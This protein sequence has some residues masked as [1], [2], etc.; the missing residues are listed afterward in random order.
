M[1]ENEHVEV[2]CPHCANK[3]TINRNTSYCPQCSMDISENVDTLFLKLDGINNKT[4]KVKNAGDSMKS[5][6]K[7]AEHWGCTIFLLPITFFCLL[8]LL[9][10]CGASF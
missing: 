7:E 1:K 4:T 6:G 5:V 8:F 3:I 2:S 9:S 10:M